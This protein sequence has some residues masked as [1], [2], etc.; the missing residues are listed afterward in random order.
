[1]KGNGLVGEL[2]K[3]DYCSNHRPKEVRKHVRV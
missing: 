1:L 2:L 3:M